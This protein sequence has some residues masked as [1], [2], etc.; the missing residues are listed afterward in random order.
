MRSTWSLGWLVATAT[1]TAYAN[2]ALDPAGPANEAEAPSGTPAP[3]APAPATAASP[4]VAPAPAA[5]S[6]P[7][8]TA[9]PPI[10]PAP[11]APAASFAPPSSVPVGCT[12][13]G[14]SQPDT[15]EVVPHYGWQIVAADLVGLTVAL[16]ARSGRLAA[17]IYLF[18]GA[19]IHSMH[20]RPGR[21]AASVLLRAG[22]PIA[23][24][25]I[26][27]TATQPDDEFPVG[28]VL[29]FGLG[30]ATAAL[31]DATLIARPVTVPRRSMT[32]TPQLSVTHD[33]IALGIA[34]GF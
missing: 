14:C 5:A 23:G 33:R 22:L 12:E 4:P 2:P 15:V 21:A 10:A 13:P 29:G 24:A 30:L 34:G 20:G 28:L 8:T 18:D 6:A 32:W 9:P 3:I 19:F 31:L 17:G 25:F 11:V 27:G 16:S 7:A 1:A 26:L